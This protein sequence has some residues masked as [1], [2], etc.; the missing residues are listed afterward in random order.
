VAV[1]SAKSTLFTFFLSISTL[2]VQ[3]WVGG[4]ITA[5]RCVSTPFPVSVNPFFLHLLASVTLTEPVLGFSVL[6]FSFYYIFFYLFFYLKPL[7]M[8]VHCLLSDVVTSDS[9]YRVYV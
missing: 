5:F 3:V 9:L 1:V 8:T 2:L 7:F 6:Y 4:G